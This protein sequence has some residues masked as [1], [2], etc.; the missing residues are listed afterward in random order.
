MPDY[1]FFQ[2]GKDV[3]VLERSDVENAALLAVKGFE[4]QFE[5]IEASNPNRALV[6]FKALRHEDSTALQT[7]SGNVLL[8]SAVS[9]I[10]LLAA[11][12]LR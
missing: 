6:R 12:I 3:V 1:C 2:K 7:Y 9:V 4:K 8:M 11:L 5:E 10:G